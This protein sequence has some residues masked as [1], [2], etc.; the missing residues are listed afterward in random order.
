MSLLQLEDLGC[1]N[2]PPA[3]FHLLRQQV[4]NIPVL[5]SPRMMPCLRHAHP[6][7]CP[8]PLHRPFS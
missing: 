8:V 1:A 3:I 5:H 7:P 4:N 6:S 2:L